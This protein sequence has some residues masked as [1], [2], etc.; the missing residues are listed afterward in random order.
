M[1]QL[2]IILA[3]FLSSTIA[4]AQNVCVGN[5][6]SVCVGSPVT[7]ENCGGGIS[8]GGVATE[9]LINPTT[10]TLTDDWWS[11]SIPIPFSFSF[12][13]SSYNNLIIG[14][15]GIVSFDVAQA[16]TNCAWSL[17]G[18]GTLPN[19]TFTDA[20]NS[21][22][23]AYQDINPALGGTVQYETIGTAPNR[24]FVVLYQDMP[25]FSGNCAGLCNYM[26]CVLNETTNLIEIHVGN[27]PNC[28][29]WN[30][31]L[32]ICGIQ[33]ST[34]T[35]AVTVAGANNA[36]YVMNQQ[37]YHFTPTSPTNTNNYTLS[38]V[39]YIFYT[40]PNSVYQW[41]GTD[42]STS[43][44]NSGILN[45]PSVAAGAPVGYYITG[46]SCGAAI[47]AVSD[48]TWVTPITTGVS[49]TGTDDVC[50]SNQGTVTATP[51]T[52]ALAPF[53]YDWTTLGGAN[54][55]TVTGVGGG[56]HT[57]V[58]TDGNGCSSTA[59]VLI[60]D[61]P[62]NYSGS[63][64][65]VSCVNGSDG[66]ATATMTP[67]T[68]TVSYLWDD[69]ATQTTQTATGLSAGTYNCVVTS[70]VG[71]SGTVTVVVT[72]IPPLQLA[73]ASQTDATCNSTANGI[74][75][76]TATQGTAPY[77]Y[78]WDI[79][80]STTNIANDLGA[81]THTVTVTDA[82]GCVVD[83]TVTI[84]EPA[85]L[86]ISML[87]S[88]F[89]ICP[90]HDT[91]L[92]V[93]GAGGSTPYTFTWSENGNVIGTGA[94]IVVDPSQTN[95][96][97]CVVLTEECGS[98]QVDSCITATF[99]TPIEP[100]LTP[101]Y[102]DRCLPG[103][104]TFANSSQNGG[105]IASS[106]IEF[107][108]LH[109]LQVDSVE[110][111]TYEYPFPGTYTVTMTSTSIYG[112][113]YS[114]TMEN[115]ITI[116]PDPIANFHFSANPTTQFSTNISMVD[117]SSPDVTN[118]NWSSPNST[119]S[120]STDR[121]PTFKYP[122]EVGQH[123]VTLIVESDLGCFDTITKILHVNSDILFF[124]PNSF[125]PN[126]DEFNQA[127]KISIMGIDVY[128]F[129]IKIFNRWGN[130][131]WESNDLNVGWDGTYNGKV[132]QDGIYTWKVTVKDENSDDKKEFNG[133]VNVI[134]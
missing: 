67:A 86:S 71:C 63:M 100:A 12:Y 11:N 132:V 85:P 17:G 91:L 69:P 49:A 102:T 18:V 125:T 105:E 87:T 37:S 23:I 78:S 29:N 31:G 10:I 101:D 83:T 108:N 32:G 41:V 39:P 47:G 34:G 118:W 4:N 130:L 95:T 9:Q 55:A 94:S 59:S 45:I 111:F 115:L 88:N 46:S 126:G 1:K 116:H 70:D 76:I 117:V 113:V 42:G 13:G 8:A 66:T 75:D 109:T 65:V 104:I 16:G 40:S 28:A 43:P 74:V 26:S 106:H 98:P 15:N 14:S 58:M 97:Y 93:T 5:D 64:T 73:I 134:K 121:Q 119:P 133:H 131:I 48:T 96:E 21:I 19:A 72:E 82:N 90:E 127:W 79:S 22:M 24:K 35:D 30:S 3:I 38:S 120:S 128:S 36:V 62:V 112:C 110:S 92:Q 25:Y 122:E 77:S 44:Y 84:N 60:N 81:G 61:T 68:G 57:V 54:T 51:N 89:Q 33:N 124:A 107:G 52:G 129:N 99:P 2:A 80:S 50:S 53:T 103:I 56:T 27:K 20:L 7:I 123:E 114:D 6:T